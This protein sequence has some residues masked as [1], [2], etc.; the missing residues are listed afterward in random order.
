MYAGWLS[1]IQISP[2]SSV[3]WAEIAWE[4]MHASVC[5]RLLLKSPGKLN[6]ES[7]VSIVV[8]PLPQKLV[9]IFQRT[10]WN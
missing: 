1:V 3:S 5:K 4:N 9:R 8:I 10:S 2:P 7:V 6:T